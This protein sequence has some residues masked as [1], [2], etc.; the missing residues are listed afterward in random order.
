MPQTAMPESQH[1][2]RYWC[3][4]IP[5]GQVLPSRSHRVMT[6]GHAFNTAGTNSIDICSYTCVYSMYTQI[7]CPV[8][9]TPVHHKIKAECLMQHR[10]F[11]L[12]TFSSCTRLKSRGGQWV[13]TIICCGCKVCSCVHAEQP[14]PRLSIS[15]VCI[16]VFLLQR[17]Q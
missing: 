14:Q 13:N 12:S 5:E 17:M 9:N 16:A 11:A 6:Q 1:A 8:H 3:Q 7:T 4:F 2:K 15:S 10:L